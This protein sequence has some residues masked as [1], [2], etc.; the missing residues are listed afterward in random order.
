M[1]QGEEGGDK[2]TSD[3]SPDGDGSDSSASAAFVA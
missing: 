3:I 1:Q 2:N